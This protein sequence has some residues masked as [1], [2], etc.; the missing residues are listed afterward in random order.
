VNAPVIVAY[1]LDSTLKTAL[2][3]TGELVDVKTEFSRLVIEIESGND[4]LMIALV[5]K[6][7]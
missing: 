5:S 2:D 1:L 3:E 4:I 6:L 7:S